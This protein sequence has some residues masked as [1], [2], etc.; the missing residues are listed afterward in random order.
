MLLDVP[1]GRF[2]RLR[3][4]VVGKEHWREGS[5]QVWLFALAAASAG[6]LAGASISLF[7]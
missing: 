5:Q 6:F 2:E 3:Y 4:Q 7:R 1:T